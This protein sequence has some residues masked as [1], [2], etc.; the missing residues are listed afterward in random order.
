MFGHFLSC[1]DVDGIA[2]LWILLP[3]GASIVPAAGPCV[4]HPRFNAQQTTIDGFRLFRTHRCIRSVG[5]GG[6]PRPSCTALPPALRQK[7]VGLLPGDRDEGRLHRAAELPVQG[8]LCCQGLWMHTRRLRS[9]P[10][11]TVP[12]SDFTHIQPMRGRCQS[13]KERPF[14]NTP[15]GS[16]RYS[17]E[18]LITPN[19]H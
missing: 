13:R 1:D 14:A 5:Q 12:V 10:A 2:F 11:F 6:Y 16:C 9:R 15:C 18:G 8:T 7:A 3:R 4:S 19:V 17:H